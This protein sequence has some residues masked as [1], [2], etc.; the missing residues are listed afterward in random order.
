MASDQPIDAIELLKADHRKVDDLFEQ[1]DKAR[2]SDT[3]ARLVEQICMALKIHTQ[4]EEEIFYPA[5]RP[6]IDDALVDEGIVEHDGAKMWIN[7]LSNAKPTDPFYDAKVKV[8][9]EDIKHHVQEEERWLRGIFA[10]SR[11]TDIDMEVLGEKLA[12]RKAEL[13]AK[14]EKSK[15]PRAKMATVSS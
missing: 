1:F 6:K 13:E 12:S 9:S 11:R 5:I 2:R 4:I 15:L 14:A 10:Q 3:K 7:D 8:L